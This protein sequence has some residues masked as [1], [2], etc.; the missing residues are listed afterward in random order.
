MDYK[1]GNVAELLG[2]SSQAIRYYEARGVVNPDK[3]KLNNYRNFSTWD[4]DI[5]I[6]TRILRS[7]GYSISEV[8]EILNNPDV[9][10][11]QEKFKSQEEKIK[12]TIEWN[13]NLLSRIKEEDKN[14]M[15]SMGMEGKYLI[16]NRPGM[17]R[18]EAPMEMNKQEEI[19]YRKF[20]KKW[21]DMAP[22]IYG[23]I[24]VSKENYENRQDNFYFGQVIDGDYK[25]YFNIK[26]NKYITYLPPKSCLY[27]IIKFNSE[28]GFSTNLLNQTIEY[29]NSQGLELK[30]DVITRIGLLNRLDNKYNC[31]HQS[32][33]PI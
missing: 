9:L 18:L 33:F 12:E 17:Y 25:D 19:E 10:D 20:T 23:S 8:T 3:S 6:R 5:L 1:I 24:R 21:I 32:W 14:I 22:F 30:G 13:L 28:T 4:L 27:T 15:D 29:M 11:L 16:Q 7:Y 31:Y 26:E 2:I